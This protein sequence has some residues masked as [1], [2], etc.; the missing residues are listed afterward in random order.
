MTDLDWTEIALALIAAISA[1]M[2]AR[3]TRTASKTEAAEAPARDAAASQWQELADHATDQ[4]ASFRRDMATMKRELQ[5]M[6]LELDWIKRKYRA[7]LVMIRDYRRAH[8][9]TQ[10]NRNI[11]VEQDL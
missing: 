5:E 6:Q 2:V 10:V 8:P 7:A 9:G 4:L 3:V 1:V 11:E